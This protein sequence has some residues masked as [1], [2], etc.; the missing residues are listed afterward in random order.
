MVSSRALEYVSRFSTGY[1]MEEALEK[2]VDYREDCKKKYHY[3]ETGRV[4][5]N[6]YPE[7]KNFLHDM[8]E[9]ITALGE[10]RDYIQSKLA[11]SDDEYS[12]H[13]NW[14]PQRTGKDI[15]SVD[16][17][18]DE[19]VGDEYA[20]YAA[21]ERNAHDAADEL[22]RLQREESRTKP[23]AALTKAVAR[24]MT[25]LTRT[26][27]SLKTKGYD[28][29]EVKYIIRFQALAIDGSE[30]GN[31]EAAYDATAAYEDEIL[32]MREKHEDDYEF[33]NDRAEALEVVRE[34]FYHLVCEVNSLD[35]SDLPKAKKNKNKY[36]PDDS[37][38]AWWE[39][40]QFDS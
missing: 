38:K 19:Y 33:Y 8:I 6:N 1:S 17:S 28:E 20:E 36:V 27:K 11:V 40:R 23:Y 9:R 29:H 7:Q 39:D 21:E 10:A 15:N 3:A 25:H 16:D 18:D 5:F 26:E 37:P 4:K 22:E 34:Y 30:Y 32:E 14:A 31:P 2:I 24:K 12:C 35:D 13:K